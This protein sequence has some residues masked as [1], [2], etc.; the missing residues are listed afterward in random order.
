MIPKSNLDDRTFDDIVDE[1][2]RL[3]P[4]Y[5]PEWTNHNPTDPGITLIELFAWM[6][7]LTLYRLNQVPEKTYL[8]L[9]ELMGLS[10][11]PPQAARA[12]IRFFPVEGYKKPVAVK[13]GTQIAAASGGDTMY[14]FETEQNITVQNNR[15]LACIN[16]RG[17]LWTD[18]CGDD[19][20]SPFRL[21]E[22]NGEIDHILYIG[23]PLFSYLLSDHTI[24][25][26]FK[27]SAEITSVRDE[28]TNFLY[29]E[30][31]DGRAWVHIAPRQ[32]IDK[33]KK[34]DNTIYI[35]GP[36]PIEPNTVNGQ[37]GYFLRAVLTEV[38]ESRKAITVSGLELQTHFGGSGFLPDLCF[39]NS[40]SQYAPVDMNSSFR[41]FSENP[42]YNEIFYLSADEIFSRPGSRVFLSFAFS[43]IYV[44]GDENENVRFSYEYWDGSNWA[45]IG[46]SPRDTSGPNRFDFKDGTFAFKQPGEVQFI[47]PDTI[48]K[49]AV[50]KEERYWLR[51]RL[52]TK[53]FSLGGEYIKDDKENWVWQFSSKVHSPVFSKIRLSYNAG[54]QQPE[55]IYTNS[56][57]S[58][59]DLKTRLR[60][61]KQNQTPE[62]LLFDISADTIPALYLGFSS[63]FPKGS[64]SLYIKIDDDR[65]SKPKSRRFS[66]FNEKLFESAA[67][68]RLLDLSWEY[69][70]GTGWQGLPVN[71]YT[72]SFHESGFIEFTAPED[73]AS[74]DQFDRDL[75]WLRVRFLSGSFEIQP[76]VTAVLTNAVYARNRTTY[77]NEIAGSGTGAPA[78]WVSPA[79][80][81]LLPGMELYIDEGSIPPANELEIMKG[82]GIPEP[83]QIDGESVWVRYKEADTFY[84]SNSHSR[85]FVVDYR[86][87]RIFFGD[88]QRGINP[89][90]RKFNIRIGSYCTGGG[91]SGNVAAGTLRTL[92]QS[93]P[94]IAGCDNPFPAEGGADM[95]TIDNLKSRAAG[96]FKSLQRA[97]TAEDFQWLSREASA[98][99]GRAWCLKEKNRQGEITVIVIPVI[100]SGETLAH[101]L[102]PSRELIR[103]V[104]GYLDE[105]KLVGT[106][107]R[108]Q[109]PLYRGFHILMTLVFKSDVMDV[110]RLKK[111]IDTALRANFHALCGGTG[112]GWEF[113]KAVT[114]GTVLKQIEKVEGILSVDEV[115]LF[116]I[117]AGVAVDKLVLKDDELPYLDEVRIENRRE[118]D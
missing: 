52:L 14:M 94:F 51:I 5:C 58:W 97:V 61:T 15:L 38:P 50:N 22:A 17:E 77:K 74:K 23:S 102:I 33:R 76:T 108:V 104:H 116:D 107:I 18:Y 27:S 35:Q 47:V 31:W 79:H 78:Q 96:V 113:G 106:K 112:G 24:Q 56:N 68:R 90:R 118:L 9:L 66:F 95:E 91:S 72:D 37:E 30:Y 16:R 4:R 43:E 20:V 87:N 6:T 12:V 53:D 85:H 115:R 63:A 25:I 93:I 29:W 105:R 64:G 84:A 92:T 3:I 26:T 83:Y 109:A 117:D 40:G 70:D 45:K 48:F 60:K 88:G 75:Y 8:S 54:I 34:R 55:S 10:L 99:V 69:W 114:G 46:E 36:V 41:I 11:I 59:H 101:R 110:E 32:T 86:E 103:R 81:P 44:P 80:G 73:M 111:N 89:P 2:I 62:T 42:E 39:S 65:S 13:A 71:D 100:P 49:T 7:E 82:E 28:I 19:A 57:F 21:F 1:A 98:S 67:E